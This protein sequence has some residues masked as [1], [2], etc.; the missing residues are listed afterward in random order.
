LVGEA[1]HALGPLGPPAEP[2]RA[3]ARFIVE[4]KA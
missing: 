4:R 1:L 3:L 2:L